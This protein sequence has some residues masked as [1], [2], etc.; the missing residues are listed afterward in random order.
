MAQKDY[1]GLGWGIS[2][3]LC[4]FLGGILAC[5]IRFL[6][7]KILLGILALPFLFGIVFWIVDFVSLVVNKKLKWLM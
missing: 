2:L 5:I 1:F 6:N 3:I 4:F 7:G